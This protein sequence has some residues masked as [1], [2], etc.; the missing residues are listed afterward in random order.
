[1]SSPQSPS[2]R[3]IYLPHGGGPLPLLGDPGHRQLSAF[4]RSLAAKISRP[5]AILVVSAHWE[6]L[7]PTLTSSGNPSLIY[8]Y[9]GFPEQSY[10]L[11]Y[12]APGAPAL[13]EDIA[14]T[15]RASGIDAGLDPQRGL[16]HGVFVPLTLI[17]PE[18]DIPCLQLSLQAD[19]SAEAHL[20]L[21][22]ALRPLKDRNI[23]VIGSGLSF[24][25]MGAFGSALGERENLAFEAW[26]AEVCCG[27]TFSDTQRRAALAGW[28]QA[29]GAAFCHPRAEHL[30]PL[31]VCAAMAGTP[32]QQIFFDKVIGKWA[33]G[34]LWT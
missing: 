23:L 2:A 32:A 7:A 22:E 30:L 5:E 25:N 33:S 29:P 8:D 9:Y 26:L 28:H 14:N 24:H 27:E 19:L 17:Y 31:H 20:K 15:L 11:R 21:G 12:P 34:Y 3:I 18:A 16:D 10:Q 6:T 1:M 13:A 4:L